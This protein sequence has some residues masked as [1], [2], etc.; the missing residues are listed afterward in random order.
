MG[1]CSDEACKPPLESREHLVFSPLGCHEAERLMLET[2]CK[3]LWHIA[4][5]P[6]MLAI[7]IL[8]HSLP[9]H[10]PKFSIRPHIEY[11][12]VVFS[13]SETN[14]G[15]RVGPIRRELEML[16]RRRV[17]LVV[18]LGGESLDPMDASGFLPHWPLSSVLITSPLRAPGESP[19]CLS[20]FFPPEIGPFLTLNFQKKSR[21][22]FRT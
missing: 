16:E 21:E 17:L 11:S 14:E 4:G 19:H 13:Y 1:C 10:F 5:T 20:P 6:H 8:I 9:A 15:V 18:Q 12:E 3:Y 2:V 7:V 22:C